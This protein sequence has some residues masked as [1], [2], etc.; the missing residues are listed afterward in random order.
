MT[1]CSC[2]GS[3]LMP[4]QPVFNMYW[5]KEE[6]EDYIR[7]PSEG[8]AEELGSPIYFIGQNE[9]EQDEVMED[10][11]SDLEEKGYDY[12]PLR[13]YNSR[14]YFEVETREV[15]ST[16]EDQYV[17]YNQIIDRKSVV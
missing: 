12:T 5:S 10:L 16:N 7:Y 3:I 15:H 13:P 17:R 14:E 6:V 2:T 4:D 1:D 8:S 11:V 9:L